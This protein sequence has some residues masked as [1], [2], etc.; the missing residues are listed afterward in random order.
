MTGEDQ[1]T[2]EH[3]VTH[4]LEGADGGPRDRI[5]ALLGESVRAD[6]AVRSV[7]LTA[8]DLDP[9]ELRAV[10]RCRLLLGPIEARMFEGL[11]ERAREPSGR[12]RLEV[13][14]AFATSGRVSV[15]SSRRLWEPDF[16]VYR[17]ST[18]DGVAL[19]GAHY[20]G[21]PYPQVG[22]TFTAELTDGGALAVLSRRFGALW[23]DGRD[24]LPVLLG[25]IEHAV[26]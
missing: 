25:R 5:G 4:L 12:A 7:R 13:L 20:F 9:S 11:D 15:R 2:G 10:R 22:P 17:L 14:R 23:R 26:R 3:A 16:S 18:G 21:P 24:V 19:V 8:L 1:V 6:F